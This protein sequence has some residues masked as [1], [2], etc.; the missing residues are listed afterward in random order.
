M[1]T[2][3]YY[4]PHSLLPGPYTTTTTLPT[5]GASTTAPHGPTTTVATT[6]SPSVSTTISYS[7]TTP[8]S[9][10]VSVVG[11]QSSWPDVASF[12]VTALL[13]AVC[14][15]LMLLTAVFIT[16]NVNLQRKL[17]DS[18]KRYHSCAQEKLTSH[19]HMNA[20]CHYDAF[21]KHPWQTAV[22]LDSSNNSNADLW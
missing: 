19:T 14:I 3:Y 21:P 18:V 6:T 2:F 12:P 5:F 4:P 15:F 20:Y 7:S 17:R 16:C 22:F 9:S 10:P 11:Y 13:L 1:H 8:S